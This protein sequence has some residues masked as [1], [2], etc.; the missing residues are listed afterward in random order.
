VS[1]PKDSLS[2]YQDIDHVERVRAQWARE[3]PDLDT[4]PLAVVARL[5]RA[6]G[7]FEYAIDQHLSEH[8]LSRQ[9]WDVLAS[10]RRVG[11]PYRLS[12]TELYQGLM[13]TSGTLTRRLAHLEQAGLI[14]RVPAESDGRSTLV[15]LTDRGR[16]LVDEL[17]AGHLDNERRLLAALDAD[18]QR[19]LAGLLAKLLVRLERDVPYPPPRRKE[20]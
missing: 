16:R 6:R 14:S 18:E 7:L 11:A 5:G 19:T 13:R 9:A 15:E 3:R 10:L 8:G 2:A 12:P 4:A 17:A 1:E 20:P